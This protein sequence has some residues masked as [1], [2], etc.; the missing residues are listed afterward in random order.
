MSVI[1][2]ALKK[3][4]REK[5]YRGN[6]TSNVAMDILRPDLPHPVKKIRLHFLVVTVAVVTAVTVTYAVMVELGF[7]PRSFPSKPMKSPS[8]NQQSAPAPLESKLRTESSPGSVSPP[9]ESQ[10]VVPAAVSREPSRAIREKENQMNPKIEAPAESKI[11]VETRIPVEMKPPDEP[12]PPVDTKTPVTPLDEKKSV[13]PE[14]AEAVPGS[15]R[16]TVEDTP[17]VSSTN[18]PSLKLSAIAWYEDPSMRFAM[19]NGMKATEGSEIEGVKVVEIK[20]TSVR[21]S[22]NGRY[23]EISMTW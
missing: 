11:P 3:L 14:K 20:P 17:N 8:L 5:A 10:Q 13:M 12:K 21:F 2:D 19:I 6:G 15:A 22:H 23:F 7:R 18:P 1:L 9:A 16:K 4:D